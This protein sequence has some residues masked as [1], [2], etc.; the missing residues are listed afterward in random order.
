MPV[1][2]THKF[3]DAKSIIIRN[4]RIFQKRPF[5]YVNFIPEKIRYMQNHG[6]VP[7]LDQ[8]V[9]ELYITAYEIEMNVQFCYSICE[10]INIVRK[11]KFRACMAELAQVLHSEI[12][13]W[14]NILSVLHYIYTNN[15]T[16]EQ[17]TAFWYI[18]TLSQYKIFKPFGYD[19]PFKI[20]LANKTGV[21]V[22]IILNG[23][24]ALDL[25]SYDIIE[26][27]HVNTFLNF[28]NTHT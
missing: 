3:L 13:D 8:D 23:Y 25:L 22:D 21:S 17:D 10:N 28:I 1:C 7:L 18:G 15:N 12:V 5:N 19:I 16:D 11:L 9:Y 14:Y 24:A 6:S 27:T 26:D 20:H 2:N 4:C